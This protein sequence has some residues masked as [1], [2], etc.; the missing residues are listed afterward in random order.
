MQSP[1]A[2]Y[3][4]LLVDL[5]ALQSQRTIHRAR[6]LLQGALG[7]IWLVKQG[8]EVYAEVKTNAGLLLKAAG[9]SSL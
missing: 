7:A 6:E 9:M 8:N 5:H 2:A 4:R 1:Y 3:R